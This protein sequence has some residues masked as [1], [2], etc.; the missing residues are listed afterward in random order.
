MRRRALD[1]FLH[2]P[3]S[4][5]GWEESTLPEPWTLDGL[6]HRPSS[7]LGWEERTLRPGHALEPRGPLSKGPET[8]A[9]ATASG[10]LP[11]SHVRTHAC[12]AL[13]SPCRYGAPRPGPPPLSQSGSQGPPEWPAPV[14]AGAVA[15]CPPVALA[16][17]Y[18]AF[19]M[20][21]SQ[22]PRTSA[23]CASS[24]AIWSLISLA[25]AVAALA[26]SLAASSDVTNLRRLASCPSMCS[27]KICWN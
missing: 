9:P 16:A 1:G 14:S 12:E 18:W 24:A 26:R 5:F 21:F 7:S 20:A 4:S 22:C 27:A 17:C 15:S 11:G 23:A 19:A 3:A 2:H 13:F 25:C 8:R 6:L 10:H